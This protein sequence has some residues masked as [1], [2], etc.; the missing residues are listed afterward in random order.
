MTSARLGTAALL[1]AAMLLA[2]PVAPAETVLTVASGS[3]D[4][5]QLDPHV[6]TKSQDKIV[7]AMMF[8]GLVRFPPGSMNPG[9]LEPDLAESWTSS[10][11]GLVWT[12]KLREGVQFHGGYGEVTAEDVVF[13]LTRAGNPE[14]SAVS[15]DYDSFES[16]E[17]LDSDT[18]RIT[19]SKP[20]P[21]LLGL[22]ANY[23]GG[24]VVSKQAVEEM[25]EG[26]RLNPIGTGPFAFV[27]YESGQSVQLAA[28][29][30]Y[31]R[32]RPAIDAVN[33]LYVPS[34]AARELAFLNGELD[35]AL[36]VR[37]ERWVNRMRNEPGVIVDVFGPGELRTL[38]MN[39]MVEPLN[40]IRVR[41][42]IAHA[43]SREELVA[44]VGASVTQP[45][46][47]PVPNGYLGHTAEVPLYPHDI[48]GAKALLAEAG[49]PDGFGL[50]AIITQRTSL[51]DPMQVVQEQLRR[52]GIAVELDV[53]EHSTFHAQIRDDLSALVLYGAARFP[54]ADTYLTQFYHSRSIVNTPT[55]VTNFSHC[56]VADAEIDAARSEPDPEQQAAL[57]AT[58][59]AKLMT[60]VCAVPLFEQLQVWARREALDY[61]FDLKAAIS[62]SPL[63]TEQATLTQ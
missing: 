33:F 53:V 6:S 57:W 19:L 23:H 30:A 60:E 46:L 61:G 12:F 17:A 41:R 36:G 5:G 43:L 42:A 54:V 14:V 20:V 11:D 52:V 58:A 51:L 45:S 3:Q 44:F 8:N 40:D 50:R 31:F 37:Q 10:P 63:I 28:N 21:S 4:A 55:A 59:Q 47:S 2:S 49:Y 24:N 22:V 29:D 7:F 56:S 48:D 16:V 32:G 18:V 38:H 25:G 27:G 62:V 15:S 9:E 34:N 13:S 26:F 39:R 35:L 1:G